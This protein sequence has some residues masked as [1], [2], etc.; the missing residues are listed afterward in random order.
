MIAARG[1]TATALLCL[2]AAPA[3]GQ[4]PFS[5]DDVMSFSFASGLVAAPA[6]D[7]VAWI[8]N[9]EGERNVWVAEGPAWEGRPLTS[10]R[11]DDGQELGGLTFSPDGNRVF[12]VRGGAPNRQGEVPDPL[13]TP[14]EEGRAVWASDFTGGES[15]HTVESGNF[16]ISP[17][18][19]RLAY[20]SG[21]EI[22]L[23]ALGAETDV[24][25]I[26]RIRGSA[27]SLTWS[28]DGSKLG[29]VSGR[30]DH[31]FIGV[32]DLS[33]RVITYLDPS[34]A[35]DGSPAWSPDGRQ[36]AFLRIPNER[37][38]HMFSP[39]REGLP[40]SIRVADVRTGEGREVWKANEGLG[41][42]FSGVN[43]STQLW[44]AAGDRLI[45]PWE[46][47]GWKHLYSVP[48]SGGDAISLTPGDFEVQFAAISPDR[49]SMIYDSNQDDI[50]RK[51]VWRAGVNGDRPEPIT[52]G[53]GVEWGAVM[54]EGGTIAFHA[55]S[56][57][58]PAHTV[59]L[60]DGERH[61]V[62]P[63]RPASFPAARMVEPEQVVFSASDGMQIHGQLFLPP[64]ASS[65]EKHPAVLFFHG[66]SRRQMLLGF[67]HRGYYHNTYAMNQMLANAG[68][69]VLSVNYRSGIGYGMEFREAENYGATG[70]S[71]FND[72]M[73][74][75]LYLRSRPDVD[76]DRIG[77]WGGSYGGYLTALGLARA[78]HLF[79]AGVDIHGVHDWNVVMNGFR[80]SY[81]PEDYPEFSQ[82]A[83]DS[84]PMAFMDGWTSPVLLIHGDD[85]RNVPFSE[86]VDVAEALDRRGVE[87]EQLIFPDEVHGFLL[88]RN[89]VAAFD[90]T[91]S[92]FDRKL[93]QRPAS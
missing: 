81:E 6:G 25:R 12:W 88:H 51:H 8:E 34:V 27:G 86:T 69:V 57:S 43:A 46:G 59:V 3:A 36:I 31:A 42:A 58:E 63:T 44:W 10:Y 87:Y 48:V 76:P 40:F 16:T 90:A 49:E 85:D 5:V 78:S 54:T 84:S 33:D 62:S 47:D 20:S 91:L 1:A 56:G 7:R 77:L 22:F 11:G 80:P 26:A 73:G 29:F 18:G 45:F 41:S 28:P 75:G 2:L 92:F 50:D 74:S 55:A 66:G 89:W 79:A 72:V 71:E 61:R 35:T 67:H 82:L 68:Y 93:K 32:L 21:R 65:G 23:L 64:G 38:V 53:T 30:G 52:S 13:S 24:E 83:Y 19:A 15:T 9:R 4:A 37:V 17:D 14:D 70:A 39:R 60:H